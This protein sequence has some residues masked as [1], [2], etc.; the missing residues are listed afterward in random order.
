VPKSRV[1]RFF[2]C[3]PIVVMAGMSGPQI[4]DEVSSIH[5]GIKVHFMLGYA[6][7]AAGQDR[8]SR[9]GP[10]FLQRPFRLQDLTKKVREVFVKLR[11]PADAYEAGPVA[12][13]DSIRRGPIST[14][15]DVKS[16]ADAAEEHRR[17]CLAG[18]N[19]LSIG[20]SKE[21][22]SPEQTVSPLRPGR[23]RSRS[24]SR[25]PVRRRLAPAP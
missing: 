18:P 9:P 2:F 24:W 13:T 23:R 8:I 7:F 16:N 20:R 25:I 19:L 4:A 5:P 21:G 15:F 6:N 3:Y 12:G 22:F 17:A 14:R 1:W 11:H 10:F